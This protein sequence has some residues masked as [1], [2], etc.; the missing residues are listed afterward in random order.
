MRHPL[1]QFL[2]QF[3]PEA[4]LQINTYRRSTIARYIP[5]ILI[6]AVGFLIFTIVGHTPILRALGMAVTISGVALI[7]QRFG[8]ILAL[9]GGLT[10][11]F[12][13]A[14]WSQ[15]GGEDTRLLVLI[16]LAL[17]AVIPVAA[18]LIWTNRINQKILIPAVVIIGLV[19][20]LFIDS[21]RS[22]RVTTLLST[23]LLYILF[24]VILTSNP[25]PDAP[26]EILPDTRHTLSIIILLLMGVINDPLF[27]LLAP[28]LIVGIYQSKLN[29]SK[30]YWGLILIVIILGI[31][32][33]II[34]YADTDWLLRS[35][36]AT[37]ASGIRV[38]YFIADGWREAS[39]WV[40]LINLVRSQFT[41]IGIILGLV[42][43]ARL[44]RW[45]PVLGITT[46]VA[47]G[48][49]SLFA[50]IY[51]G[52]D[53]SVLLLPMMIIHVLWMTYAIYALGQWL[54]KSFANR[55][56]ATWLATAVFTLLPLVLLARIIGVL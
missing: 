50:L 5:A 16:S 20:W 53:S 25:R 31:R 56:E 34:Q 54:Q 11:A 32:G 22:L 7:L 43:L 33:V 27:V 19:F 37:E 46:L 26:Q 21:P 45:Y 8:V 38:P 24:D 18:F 44:S 12:S 1:H 23:G 36:A 13:P 51:F 10:L 4:N 39:R 35:A 3:R 40:Y 29:I 6:G 14:F 47:Y 48:A 52:K 49:Y 42:G 2:R 15:T 17:L 9:I 55:I 41:D 28:A 30:W